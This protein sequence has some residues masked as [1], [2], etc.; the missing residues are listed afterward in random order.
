[1][2]RLLLMSQRAHRGG[3]LALG[4]SHW[5]AQLNACIFKKRTRLQYNHDTGQKKTGGGA[6]RWGPFP[7]SRATTLVAKISAGDSSYRV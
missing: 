7:P 1:M 2:Y 3:E 6:S 5:R 4:S